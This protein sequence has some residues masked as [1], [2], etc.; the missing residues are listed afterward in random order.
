[1]GFGIE[2][3]DE[4]VRVFSQ[5]PVSAINIKTMPYPGFPTDLQPIIVALLALG[6]GTSIVNENVWENRF[7]YVDELRRLGANII[8]TGRTA[9]I[10]GVPAYE[11]SKV[12]ATDL[13]AGAAMVLSALAAKGETIVHDIKYIDRGYEYFEDKLKKLGADIERVEV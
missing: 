3:G 7:Q 10:Q 12:K 11:G 9:V 6:V 5:G 1:M 8:V 4:E 2:E 13:R